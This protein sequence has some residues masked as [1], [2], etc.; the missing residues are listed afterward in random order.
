MKSNADALSNSN[1]ISAQK[2]DTFLDEITQARPHVNGATH[3]I[4]E[5]TTELEEGQPW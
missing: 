4:G 2:L 5:D 1:F 3:E